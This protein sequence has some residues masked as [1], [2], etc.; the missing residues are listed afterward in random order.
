[1][2]M[3]EGRCNTGRVSKLFTSN[4]PVACSKPLTDA[5]QSASDS[6]VY[7]RSTVDSLGS[8]QSLAHDLF[9]MDLGCTRVLK[10]TRWTGQDW[11]WRLMSVL[12]SSHRHIVV[13]VPPTLPPPLLPSTVSPGLYRSNRT[14]PKFFM[15]RSILSFSSTFVPR[16]AMLPSDCTFFRLSSFPRTADCSHK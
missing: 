2:H 11:T 8:G 14:H 6:G 12:I 9:L 5:R 1:M 3:S 7:C 13:Y 16:S 15:C 4:L 10:Q